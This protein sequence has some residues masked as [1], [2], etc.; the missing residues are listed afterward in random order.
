VQR[1]FYAA[2]GTCQMVMVHT[3]GGMVGGDHLDIQVKAASQ[4]SALVTTAAAHKVYRSTGATAQQQIHLQVSQAACLEW[5]PGE[6]II[7]NGAHYQQTI[8][9]ELAPG[10]LWLGWDI[11][12]FGR[13]ARGERFCAGH[14]Q[15]H[16]EVWQQ[17]KPL[18]IDR[19]QLT[20]GS[21]VLDSPHGLAGKPVIATL[22]LLG[23]D[24]SPTMLAGLR[25]LT[26][27]QS[28]TMSDTADLGITQLQSGVICRYR[29]ASTQA[30][31]S[32]L[33]RVW[34]AIKSQVTDRTAS[35]PRVWG[36]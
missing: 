12:R 28:E 13:S 9:V 22:V 6:T 14:W 24:I 7:F 26:I 1:P 8:Q 27:S 34:Q 11:T 4:V 5:F 15:S 30:A 17:G 36:R 19:Q 31:R 2:D 23:A 21:A 3:A 16:T 33:I 10:A 25:G 18:W 29:G 20:G 35:I 32:H